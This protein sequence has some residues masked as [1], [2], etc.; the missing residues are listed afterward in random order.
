VHIGWD[1]PIGA[2]S[3]SPSNDVEVLTTKRERNY[4]ERVK[5]RED[6]AIKG[7]EENRPRSADNLAQQQQPPPQQQT[8]KQWVKKA[9]RIAKEDIGLPMNFRSEMRTIK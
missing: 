8:Q 7:A 4:S 9:R 2:E 1:S 6:G 5:F 3:F